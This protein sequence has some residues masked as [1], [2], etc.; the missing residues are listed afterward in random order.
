MRCNGSPTTCTV[1]ERRPEVR[2]VGARLEALLF[3]AALRP[4]ANALGFYGESVAEAVALTIAR[5]QHDPLR[6]TLERALEGR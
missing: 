3:A 4:L 2:E 5:K 6:E 1:P